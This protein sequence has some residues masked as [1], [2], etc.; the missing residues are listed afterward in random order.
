MD[1]GQLKAMALAAML[2]D[3]TAMFLLAPGLYGASGAH[4]ALYAAMRALGRLTA[5]IMFFF[6]AEG[7]VHTSSRR[8]Y[9][10]R[11]LV[12][13][14]VSQ[15]PYSLSHYDSLVLTDLNV[16]F[17]LFLG[18]LLL[19]A[20]ETAENR[21]LRCLAVAAA[22]L[23]SFPC[24]WGLTGPFL[25]WLFYI[26]R[27]DRQLQMRCYA[28]LCALQVFSSVLFLSLNKLHWYGELW[29]AG[30]FLVIPLLLG[31]NGRPGKRTPA[32]KWSFYLVYPLHLLVFWLILYRL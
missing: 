30:M 16:G 32:G 10:L 18:F 7:F 3:H 8:R 26:T 9:G 31:Y 6:L 20:W 12:F 25:I 27:Q 15:I 14:L 28:L 19:T 2:I 22:V 17:T 11:L 23:L 24:D 5:P 1:R 29:Q 4:I 13:A 21:L